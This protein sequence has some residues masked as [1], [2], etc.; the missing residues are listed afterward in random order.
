MT[1]SE[2]EALGVKWKQRR[3]SRP[4]N[5]PAC[6]HSNQGLEASEGSYLTGDYHCTDC[7]EPVAKKL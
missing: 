2:A 6:K 1:R 7:G 5:L 3:L 4:C